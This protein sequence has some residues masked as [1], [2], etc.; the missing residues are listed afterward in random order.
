MRHSA[1]RQTRLRGPWPLLSYLGCPDAFGVESH[2]VPMDTVFDHIVLVQLGQTATTAA[3]TL[4]TA[5]RHPRKEG[6]HYNA[7][8]LA[9][10]ATKPPIV[11][12]QAAEAGGC[13]A[14]TVR[15]ARP[16][17]WMPMRS[18]ICEHRSQ[19]SRSSDGQL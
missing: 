7:K 12:A 3:A 15:R 4:G 17:M 19:R 11:L 5:A 13:A 9:S 8:L 14:S 18:Q 16:S 6:Y 1:I 2:L 10:D